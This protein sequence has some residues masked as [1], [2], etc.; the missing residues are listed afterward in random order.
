[1]RHFPDQLARL[2]AGL[3]AVP[4]TEA[5]LPAELLRRWVSADG[6]YRLEIQ[7]AERLTGNAAL[8]RFVEEVRSVAGPDVTG[9][10][11]INIEAGRAVTTAFYEAFGA[12]GILI[13]VLLYG[14]L[15]RVRE[16]ATVL[17]PLLL[18]GLLTTAFTVVFGIQFNF[19]NIIALPLLMGIGV[20]S[21]LHILHRYKTT[22]QDD[23]PL[24]ATSS[25]R[26]VLFS[27]LTSAA[28]FG[29]LAVSAH[30]GTASMGIMLTVGL[31]MTLLC[32]LVVLPALLQRYVEP[33]GSLT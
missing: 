2:Q 22:G 13:T 10:P 32:T 3:D 19:A 17:A 8:A 33:S 31:T 5:A 7:P 12:A 30:A 1:M 9:T 24:L 27:A 14:V 15:R 26:A 18:A 23:V 20:D 4:V 16:V 21:A 28:S 11:V 25:A 6:R 29:N